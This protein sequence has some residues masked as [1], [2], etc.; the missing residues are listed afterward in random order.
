M[1]IGG[2]Q[3]TTLVDYP[4]K[5]ASIVFLSGCN[6]R[7]GYC[8]NAPLATGKL[9]D[10][11]EENVFREISQRKKYVDAVVITG[12]E[13]TIWPDLPQRLQQLKKEGFLVKLDTNG[14]NPEKLR[15][16]LESGDVDFVAM[17]VKAPWAKYQ[18]VCGARLDERRIH[19][20]IALLKQTGVDY[21]FR[22][23]VAPGLTQNDLRRIGHML[24]P[25][26]RWFLQVFQKTDSLMDQG[27]LTLAVLTRHQIHDVVLEFQG[28][29][30]EC[31]LRGP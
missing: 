28:S 9:P 21:E 31:A 15:Q 20:S 8:Y 13:P 7:C 3:K 14:L 10:L 5:I 16:I 23:T 19:E 11:G 17:D 29:F 4:G 24:L 26:K 12:G 22:T 25:A 1:R 6:M 2:F 18:G 30:Q 27:V